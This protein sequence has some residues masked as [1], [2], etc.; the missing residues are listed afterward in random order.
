MRKILCF[1]LVCLLFVSFFVSCS[2]PADKIDPQYYALGKEMVGLADAFLADEVSLEDAKARAESIYTRLEVLPLLPKGDP[3]YE[4][5]DR[6]SVYVTH[7]CLVFEST[8]RED[9]TLALREDLGKYGP[10]LR[11]ILGLPG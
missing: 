10:K 1:F 7:L 5:T 2:S 9:R 4:E 3:Q 6:V 11:S 8:T